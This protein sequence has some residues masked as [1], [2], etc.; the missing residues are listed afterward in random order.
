MS[1][2]PALTLDQAR[3]RAYALLQANQ[4]PQAMGQFQEICRVAPNDGG[5][6]LTLGT[7]QGQLGQYKEAE[8][9]LRRVLAI[10]PGNI[11]AH[12][13]L[14]RVLLALKRLPEGA[15]CFREVIRLQPNH[16][17]GHAALGLSLQMQGRRDEALAAWRQAA[18]LNNADPDTHFNIARLL[19]GQQVSAATQQDMDEGLIHLEAALRLKPDF[20]DALMLSGDFHR[21]QGKIEDAIAKYRA[22][23]NL[24]P[25]H[26][27]PVRN[28]ALTL[29]WMGRH[30][31]G[32]DVFKR[33]VELNPQW[34]SLHSML[35]LFLHYDI[36]M[37]P[38]AIFEEHRKWARKYE[39]PFVQTRTY[40]N[41]PRPDRPLRVGYV[42]PNL[43]DHSV[44]FF[45][46]PILKYQNPESIQ[47][48]CYMEVNETDARTAAL[49]GRMT[50]WH[51]T[52]RKSDDEVA[53]LIQQDGIDV[54]VDL[55]GHTA[56]SR[57]AV[58]ARRP[59]PVQV[60]YL[61]YPDTTGM[62]TMTYRLTDASADPPGRTERLHTETLV[63]IEQGFLCFSPPAE[64]RAITALPALERG[65]VTFGSTNYLPKINQQVIAVWAQVL[66]TVPGSHLILKNH[67][68]GMP[69][70]AEQYHRMFAAQG[71]DS[72]R[73]TIRGYTKSKAE[74]LKVYADTDIALDTF[75]YNGT[76]TTC[77]ALWMGIPVVTLAGPVHAARVGA[78]ILSQVGLQEFV[79][80][81][82][83]Q[84]VE[85]ATRAAGDLRRLSETRATLRERMAA[86]SLCDGPRFCKRLE[87]A[88]RRMWTAWCEGQ[89]IR[90]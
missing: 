82:P 59:A 1:D 15:D 28:L 78:S 5:A 55:G 35:L 51:S 6:W 10:Q 19:L 33:A 32:L 87:A 2:K 24:R 83:E 16:A 61:G 76:T 43:K 13:I 74:H 66:K 30:Q 85:A 54:L 57:L 81:S 34:T 86:S 68:I 70:I 60:A 71:I 80:D 64:A 29:T 46:E 41:D 25:G 8:S 36:G 62:E 52:M 7:L 50:R 23:F 45:L 3:A 37:A 88:Y 63:R 89:T 77:D 67:D 39:Q 84:Y 12:L 14:G 27:D 58:F 20:V 69:G 90:S 49:L 42:S 65:Y 26:K 79:A 72:E 4:L 44:I 53:E 21:S 48:F 18:S 22:A 56:G 31:D 9:S 40:L 17:P 38:E 73:I 11:N 47:N 75:P